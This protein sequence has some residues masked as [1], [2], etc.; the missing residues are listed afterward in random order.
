MKK[1][2]ILML[3][4]ITSV[5]GFS[6][7][8]LVQ[9]GSTG[10]A[11]WA[12]PGASGGT[13]VD[14]T[15]AV[16]DF[17]SW[18]NGVTFASGDEVWIASGTYIVDGTTNLVDGVNVYGS[19]AGT[20]TSVAGREKASNKPWD[21]TG[22]TVIDGGQANIVAFVTL[23][24]F[25]APTVFDGITVTNFSVSGADGGFG[26]MRAIGTFTVQNC[27]VNNNTFTGNGTGVNGGFYIQ[28]GVSLLNSWLHHNYAA[29]GAV[30][31]SGAAITM[32]G[33]AT[34]KGCTIEY[35]RC[36]TPSG[37]PGSAGGILIIANGAANAGGGTIQDN[38]IQ[39]NYGQN[40][41]GLFFTPTFA[42][43]IEPPVNV[44]T[45]IKN[46]KFYA[47]RCNANGGAIAFASAVNNAR[48]SV[49][50][51]DCTFRGD[52]VYN[53]KGGAI[54]AQA[55]GGDLTILNHIKNCIFTDNVSTNFSGTLNQGVAI[56]IGK[57]TT[58]SNCVFANNKGA[59]V[60]N[61]DQANSAVTVDV[62]LL[63]NTFANNQ[64]TTAIRNNQT[65]GAVTSLVAKNNIFWFN[66]DNSTTGSTALTQENNAY[67]NVTAGADA[68][69]GSI[70][71]LTAD[72]T[73]VFPTSGVGPVGIS[74]SEIAD[75]SLKAGS[76]AIDAGATLSEV[77]TD[78]T[79]MARPKGAAYDIGAYEYS[80]STG[81]ISTDVFKASVYP[82]VTEGLL[83]I[84]P[85][86]GVQS[87]RMY[88]LT[89]R[90]VQEWT[91]TNSIDISAHRAGIYVI[92]VQPEQGNPVNHKI[93]KK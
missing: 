85:A 77:L 28:T 9:L 70:A 78:I 55:T 68:G 81:I 52:T 44:V 50:I 80:A 74:N 58:I 69:T 25:A 10:A 19:F 60:I 67:D 1:L 64:T 75:W 31:A 29:K 38:T 82:S 6:A 92:Q 33:R 32:A 66:S 7:R 65:A 90:K 76:P 48:F 18:Y 93:V 22:K 21:F 36:T 12:N 3:L 73:F 37:N 57:S 51:E 88:D 15:V 54:F 17:D 61:I 41:G 72:N 43:E 24:T 87:I 26:F 71:T 34:V 59:N 46:N 42:D 8:Y 86:T 40:G 20:E 79:G 49:S 5:P 62:S 56:H 39:Y 84:A 89:G 47:N 11:T 13:L 45:L 23:T 16:K 83:M 14:L 91:R 4:V 2:Y 35:N 53:G 30:T 63:N 27:I